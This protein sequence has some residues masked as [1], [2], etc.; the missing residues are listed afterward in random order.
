MTN[1]TDF[2]QI[3][4]RK[5]LLLDGGF[6]SMLQTYGLEEGDFRG[7]RFREHP[8]LQKGNNDLLN[9]TAPAAAKAVHTAYLD[10]GSDIITTNTFNANAISMADY[11]M[12]EH[13]AEMNRAAAQLCKQLTRQYSTAEKPRFVAGSVGPTNKTASMS[14][15]V[16]N[17]A[18]RS[19]T[20]DRFFTIY[21][22]Q[23]DALIERSEE[24]RVGKECRS[25]WSPYH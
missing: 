7:E 22:E 6:G 1:N 24:R 17:P 10:A 23:I 20:Y 5:I 8:L 3:L 15:D 25:R 19:V 18:F 21:F 16:N 11:G 14:D 12:E 4:S 13:V 2:K 9:L